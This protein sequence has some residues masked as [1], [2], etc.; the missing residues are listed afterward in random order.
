KTRLA[1]EAARALQ[2]D[3]VDGA[4]FL[5]LATLQ[6]PEEVPAAIVNALGIVVVSGESQTQAT[7]RFLAAKHLLLV[8]DNFEHVLPAARFIGG[9]LDACSALTVLA[10]SREPLGL[11]A[12]QR[13]PVSPLALPEFGTP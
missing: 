2:A 6:R 12:E 5:S 4:Y 3:F 9:L 8:A 1:L 10:T 7:K 13:Y 11:Q